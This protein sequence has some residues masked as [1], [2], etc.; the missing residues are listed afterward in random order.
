M[1]NPPK[2]PTVSP[3]LYSS[4]INSGPTNAAAKNPIAKQPAT[5]TIS[6]PKG[7]LPLLSL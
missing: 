6:V 5:F 7:K 3:T 2:M 1:V 4:R